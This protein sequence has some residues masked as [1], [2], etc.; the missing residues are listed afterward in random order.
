MTIYIY[1]YTLNTYIYIYTYGHI[2]ICLKFD[3]TPPRGHDDFLGGFRDT[4]M[5]RYLSI[6]IGCSVQGSYSYN[7][8]DGCS[9]RITPRSKRKWLV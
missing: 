7:T 6:C 8:E 9:F 3:Y 4:H 5:D 1:I 2:W